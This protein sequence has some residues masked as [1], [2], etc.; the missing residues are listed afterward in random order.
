MTL[1]EA[2]VNRFQYLILPCVMQRRK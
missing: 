1:N 2:K